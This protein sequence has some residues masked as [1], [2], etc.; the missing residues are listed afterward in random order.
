MRE[1]L[2]DDRGA[3]DLVLDALALLP[4]PLLPVFVLFVRHDTFFGIV[5]DVDAVQHGQRL[6]VHG[7]LRNEPVRRWQAQEAGDQGGDAKQ[8]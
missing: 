7:C 4:R 5:V 1:A 2:L 8:D 6:G 3:D